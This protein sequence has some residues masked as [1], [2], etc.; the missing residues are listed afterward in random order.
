MWLIFKVKWSTERCPD[1]KDIVTLTYDGTNY[2]S[3]IAKNFG[4]P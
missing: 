1:N 3:V 2:N 4:T